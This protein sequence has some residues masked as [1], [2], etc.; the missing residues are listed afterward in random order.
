MPW[1]F[2]GPLI[3][4]WQ[5]SGSISQ[6]AEVASNSVV[7]TMPPASHSWHPSVLSIHMKCPHF[8]PQKVASTVSQ[9]GAL[10]TIPWNTSPLTIVEQSPFLLLFLGVST[11]LDFWLL[12]YISL[13]LVGIWES[14]YERCQS[15]LCL[16]R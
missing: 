16:L 4:W 12:P 14:P 11:R 3:R 7:N 9:E 8:N 6:H 1:K 5:A 13:I 2:N 10:L 15:K